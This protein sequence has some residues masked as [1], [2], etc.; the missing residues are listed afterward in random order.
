MS[1][2]NPPVPAAPH[3][4]ESSKVNVSIDLDG[5]RELVEPMVSAH[6]VALFDIEWAST[7]AG[8]VLRVFIERTDA[9]GEP[10]G[11]VNIDHCVSVSRDLSLALDAADL[12]FVPYSLEVS[13]P[14]ADRPLK[15]A[16]DYSRQIG[17]LAKLKLIEPATDGQM[18]LRGK[19]LAV[20]GDVVSI[21][22]DGKH[23]QVDIANVKL[24]KLVFELGSQKK[25]SHK[26]RQRKR[27]TGS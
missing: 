12:I 11:G 19:L 17:R 5:V 9:E 6:G 26:R 1:V 18:V 3:A 8:K 2:K 20:E 24:A 22:V 27:R 4:A 10:L 16:R 23:H 21:E 13:S 14:G 15:T 7:P 25:K